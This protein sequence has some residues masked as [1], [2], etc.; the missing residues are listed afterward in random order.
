M[1]QFSTRP[2]EIVVSAR[3]G[4]FFALAFAWSWGGWL[5]SAML[6][7][8][9]PVAVNTLFFIAGFGPSIAAVA[10]VVHGGGRA[11]LRRWLQRCLQ[12]REIWRWMLLA[13]LFPVAFMGLAATL[14]VALGGSLPPS[15][16]AGQ[17]PMVVLNF[18]LIFLL[19]G[20]LG[21]E[22]GWR[23]HALPALQ[24]RWGWRVASLVL[25]GVWA[26][27]HLPLFYLVGTAQSH[28]PMALYALTTIASSVVFAWLFNRT[29]GSVLP[30]LVLHTAVNA[31]SSV[32]PVMVM[33]DGSNLRP[34]QIVVGILT[35]TAMAL[36]L[37][38]DPH[39][40]DGRTSLQTE[41]TWH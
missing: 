22:F 6:K 31:W 7:D 34:F 26:L 38:T 30:V 12:W 35:L 13:F 3:L 9:S 33:P 25:G 20:P 29:T 19:G 8:E 41:G 36:L 24:L 10:V 4:V 1:T 18:F 27:W 15:P 32:I 21:E 11:G 28:L 39:M 40:R 2:E 37:H 16:T 17:V 14:H 5:L 23:G